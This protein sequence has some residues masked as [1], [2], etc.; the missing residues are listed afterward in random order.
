MKKKIIGTILS[1]GT[2]IGTVAPLTACTF[3]VNTDQYEI[4]PSSPSLTYVGDSIT[5]TTT[6]N[7]K[8]FEETY[9][10]NAADISSRLIKIEGNKVTRTSESL[11]GDKQD[12]TI[13]G[14]K[15]HKTVSISIINMNSDA[16]YINA[17]CTGSLQTGAAITVILNNI[18]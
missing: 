8:D 1:A 18:V 11:N 16:K 3:E 13:T 7:G 9:S 14:D 4:Q 6:L 2:V 12:I 17:Y 5:L 15:S 10:T